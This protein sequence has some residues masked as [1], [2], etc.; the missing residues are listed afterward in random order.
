MLSV[1]SPKPSK[2]YFVKSGG[3]FSLQIL[4]KTNLY[5]SK[6]STSVANYSLTERENHHPFFPSELKRDLLT[7]SKAGTD[8]TAQERGGGQQDQGSAL[9]RL[10]PHAP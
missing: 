5:L 9:L 1:I 8:K 7:Y 3:Y 6:E 4:Y 10:I 2:G